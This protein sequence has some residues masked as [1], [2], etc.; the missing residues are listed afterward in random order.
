MLLAQRT[1]FNPPMPRYGATALRRSSWV[2]RRHAANDTPYDRSWV[3]LSAL[4]ST[5]SAGE[6]SRRPCA[7]LSAALLMPARPLAFSL[8]TRG[9]G[10]WTGRP[11]D[12]RKRVFAISATYHCSKPPVC[13]EISRIATDIPGLR[14][15]T[16]T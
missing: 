2:R 14:A 4:L 16:E 9:R 11:L 5:C 12:L 10:A 13:R 8:L 7:P 1:V 15:D 3:I 6:F